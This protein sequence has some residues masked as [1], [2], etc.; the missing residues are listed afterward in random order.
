MVIPSIY[1]LEKNNIQQYIIRNQDLKEF[2][3]FHLDLK[4]QVLKAI[5]SIIKGISGVFYI[6]IVLYS[7]IFQ[8]NICYY[9]IT[10]TINDD[11]NKQKYVQYLTVV[12][13]KVTLI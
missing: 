11:E 8:N 7:E 1:L 13:N 3:E 5:H 6:L 2:H 9:L 10:D 4:R 12:T